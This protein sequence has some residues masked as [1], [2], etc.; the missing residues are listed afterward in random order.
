[1]Y[2]QKLIDG[3]PDGAQ[4]VGPYLKV[5]KQHGKVTYF[6]G[7]DNYID[8]L[9][10]DTRGERTAW[11]VL[12]A[13]KHVRAADITRVIGISKRTL[14]NWNSKYHAEGISA[15]LK[16]KRVVRSSRVL[17][18]EKIAECEALLVAGKRPAE[19]ARLAE[20]EESTLRKAIAQKRVSKKGTLVTAPHLRPQ[21]KKKTRRRSL[22]SF[23]PTKANVAG[24]TPKQRRV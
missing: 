21:R 23:L 20:I 5:L 18:P 16:K 11:C 13:N 15:F 10:G 8:H 1:M 17:T 24:A 2:K 22:P 19:V 3:F 14:M 7:G 6:V 4:D 9:V 12:M